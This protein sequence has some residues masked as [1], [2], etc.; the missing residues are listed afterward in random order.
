MDKTRK[1]AIPITLNT[2][3]LCKA[4]KISNIKNPQ[5]NFGGNVFA[6]HVENRFTIALTK[7]SQIVHTRCS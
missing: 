4:L 3:Q 6:M 5:T 2:L 1:G 7:E